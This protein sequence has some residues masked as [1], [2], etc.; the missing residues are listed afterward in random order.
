MDSIHQQ[1]RESASAVHAAVTDSSNDNNRI[2]SATENAEKTDSFN[3]TLGDQSNEMDVGRLNNSIE[4]TGIYE[5]KSSEMV[6]SKNDIGINSCTEG[7]NNQAS[8]ESNGT[9]Q[10]PKK[11][12][13]NGENSNEANSMKRGI[14]NPSNEEYPSK[15]NKSDSSMA[16]ISLAD[17]TNNA[18]PSSA[19]CLSDQQLSESV[20]VVPDRKLAATTI[21]GGV[22]S[23]A[24][25]ECM[26]D[27]DVDYS[28]IIDP[29][30]AELIKLED[31]P[32]VV[33]LHQ[34]ALRDIA[35]LGSALQ[36][37]DKYHHG[38]DDGWKND[39][40]GNLQLYD[41]EVVVNRGYIVSQPSIKPIKI[42]FYDW[43]AKSAPN[44]NSLRG[45]ELLFSYVYHM[46]GTPPMA[47]KIMAYSLQRTAETADQRLEFILH[48]VRRISYDPVV[49]KQ[50][51]WQT[52]KSESPE[53]ALGGAFL[54]GRRI[55]W[56]RYEAL[57][58]AFVRDEEFGCLWKAVWVEDLDTFDLEAGE[59]KE[60]MK[61]WDNK[62]AKLNKKNKG[63]RATAST[64]G[65]TRFASNAK[66][67]VDGIENGIVLAASS[68]KASQ[69]VLWPARV[70]HVAETNLTSAG[71]VVSL[72]PAYSLN[73]LYFICFIFLAEQHRVYYYSNGNIN[74]IFSTAEA[75]CIKKSYPGCLLG[76][77]L[78]W[79][80]IISIKSGRC[81][82]SIFYR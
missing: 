38:A 43:V 78:E 58:I 6:D 18:T 44:S 49:L 54:I 69:G 32:T 28:G 47:K 72:K 13:A 41:K 56:Q 29:S 10:A 2:T 48:A 57:V 68:N 75:E 23:N 40:S 74:A 14:E 26:T 64:S 63:T 3:Q 55:I 15:K 36:I 31:I 37:G 25:V 8:L 7:S 65:S 20:T 27:D 81:Q 79:G 11:I 73:Y 67:T 76:T 77:F 82:R 9:G 24:D 12:L 71:T 4:N 22:A 21:N 33:P 50:D 46:K 19:K 60:A 59:L 1:S 35:E 17:E 53:G 34:P 61:K 52:C 39:W 70:R 16:D 30:F 66:F 5:A 80:S 45:L 62:Q 42:P 51:G